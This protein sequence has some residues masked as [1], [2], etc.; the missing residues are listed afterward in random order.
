M[1]KAVS[2]SQKG[3]KQKTAGRVTRFLKGVW[4]ELKKV[5]WPNRKELVTY[6]SV[7]LVSVFIVAILIWVVDSVFS[8]LLD[9]VI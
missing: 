9:L 5:H 6:V 8:F 3:K 4:N 2:K 1:A 7:V